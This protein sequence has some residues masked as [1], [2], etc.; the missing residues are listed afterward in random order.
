MALRGAVAGGRRVHGPA[1]REARRTAFGG[2]FVTDAFRD[3]MKVLVLIGS[4]A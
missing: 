2:M 1:P 4:A 3:F